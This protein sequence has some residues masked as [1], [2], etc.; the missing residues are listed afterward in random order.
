MD[1]GLGKLPESKQDDFWSHTSRF[2]C[3][4]FLALLICGVFVFFS[5]PI[6]FTVV[7]YYLPACLFRGI[8][9][10]WNLFCDGKIYDESYFI[11]GWLCFFLW[12][13]IGI[14]VGLPAGKETAVAGAFG[15]ATIGGLLEMI[16]YA[17]QHMPLPPMEQP[18]QTAFAVYSPK[19]NSWQWSG[20]QRELGPKEDSLFPIINQN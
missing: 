6:L 10:R 16:Y 7:F 9:N 1:W 4:G 19:K 20:Y 13:L 8:K 3:Y 18:R 14:V 12:I 11:D 17:A 15:A 5:A 2:F